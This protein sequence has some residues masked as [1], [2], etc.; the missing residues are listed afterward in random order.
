MAASHITREQ[1]REMDRMTIEEMGLPGVVLMENAGRGAAGV[2]A[3]MLKGQ[4]SKSIMVMCGRGNNGG[5]G[6][7]VARYMLNWGHRVRVC[8][9][10]P[11]DEVEGDARTQMDVLLAMHADVRPVVDHTELAAAARRFSHTHLVVDAMFGIGLSGEVHGIFV[12]A[13][14]VVN[15]GSVPVLSLDVP[16]GLEADTGKPL[17]TA[18]EADRTVT[19]H[20]PKVGFRQKGA[21]KYVGKVVVVDIGIP[22]DVTRAVLRTSKS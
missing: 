16:S 22:K 11:I 10:C 5:D 18:V 19:F 1:M 7:V 6:Y 17:G 12:E 4:K 3:D 13:I 14:D 15:A 8:A 20:A 9:L 21:S 2:A